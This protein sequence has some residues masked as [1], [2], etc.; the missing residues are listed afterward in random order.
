[1]SKPKDENIKRAFIAYLEDSDQLRFF[2]ALTNFCQVPYIGV[3]SSPWGDDF[4][5][6]WRI[7]ADKDVEWVGKG[8]PITPTV[9]ARPV[10]GQDD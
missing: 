3:A 5:D 10:R 9:K 2:Q 4:K 7:E 6:L 1:M 8:E